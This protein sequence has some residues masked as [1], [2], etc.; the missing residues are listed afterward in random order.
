MTPTVAGK[1]RH[2]TVTG[3]P[4]TC[5]VWDSNP[6]EVTAIQID[7]DS[8]ELISNS[9]CQRKEGREGQREGRKRRLGGKK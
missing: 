7:K 4:V 3:N 1:S 9:Q 6:Q 5:D 2:E 8:L